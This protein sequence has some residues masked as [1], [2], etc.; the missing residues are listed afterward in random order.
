MGTLSLTDE[1]R[2]CNGEKIVS[3]I[4]GAG[5]TGQLCIKR[6]KVERFLTPYTKI[7]S[8][9]I[10]DL[11]VRPEAINIKLL[12]ENIGRTLSDINHSKILYGPPSRAMEIKAK[13]NKWDLIKL[14]SFC[15]AKE[16]INKAKRQ[17]SEWEK[18]IANETT[19][20][21]LLYKIY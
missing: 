21:R 13:I 3:L 18:I 12:E 8:K 4:N 10:K 17:P 6:M 19:N 5:K 7:N 16:A 15:T 14:K 11:K 9:W 1:A 2:I 20:K